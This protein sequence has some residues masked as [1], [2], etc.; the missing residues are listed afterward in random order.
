[1]KIY[2]SHWTKG[3][4]KKGDEYTYKLFKL[5]SFFAKKSYGEVHLITDSDGAEEL[6]DLRFDSIDLSLNALPDDLRIA[7]SLGKIMA[8][9]VIAE[10]GEPFLHI[11]N[12][13]FLFKRLDSYFED[14][15]VLTQHLEYDTHFFY[16]ASQFIDP[17]VNKYFF[18]EKTIST[19][20]NMG[21]FGGINLDFI[22]FF[23]EES[24]KMTLDPL[25]KKAIQQTYFNKN[26]TA[27]CMIEQ[28]YMSLLADI[29]NVP[30][31][32]L[33]HQYENYNEK[34]IEFGY[35]HLWAAKISLRKRLEPK[36]DELIY[37]YNL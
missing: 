2:L 25:N 36:I 37:Y 33:F 10:K 30:V 18:A 31:T 17:L 20:A 3:K 1:M 21:I 4:F 5:S 14:S 24:L 26:F 7:W 9:K 11:D 28:Y 35:T 13:I 19:S 29:K 22:K 27:A 15:E 34:A 16:S 6:K 8:Y 32:Y 23:A 12:D